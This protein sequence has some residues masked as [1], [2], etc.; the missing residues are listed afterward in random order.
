MAAV[1]WD[2]FFQGMGRTF[3]GSG[4]S[5]GLSLRST[6]RAGSRRRGAPIRIR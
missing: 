1:P 4:G 6:A 5:A 3:H 2:R